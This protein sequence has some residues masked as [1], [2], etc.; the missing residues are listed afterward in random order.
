MLSETCHFEDLC[1]SSYT[2]Q[3]KSKG[4]KNVVI[5]LTTRPMHSSTKD[6]NK[7]EPQIFK[8]YDFK[9]GGIDIVDQM[10]YYFTTRAKSLWWV[11]IVVY[12]VLETARVNAKTIWGIK[13]GIDHHKLKSFNFGWDL[14]K[15]LT[16]AH[17]IRRYLN[18]LTLT[19]QLKR[20][21]FLSTAFVLPEP[22]PK[23]VKRFECTTK[24]KNM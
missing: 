6:D 7:S 17:V 15:T 23:N 14:A 12:Y 11:I 9:K 16:M 4:K 1:L 20:N 8:F 19:V 10:N 5:L 13:N 24:R 18:V 3:T 22:K 21:L 2:V